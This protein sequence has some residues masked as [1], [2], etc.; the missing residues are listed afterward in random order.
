MRRRTHP[1]HAEQHT[2]PESGARCKRAHARSIARQY[3]WEE[4]KRTV[5]D[6][7]LPRKGRFAGR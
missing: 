3:K 2:P 4:Y 1:A 6:D 7:V 5:L